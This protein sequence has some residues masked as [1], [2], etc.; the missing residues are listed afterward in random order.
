MTLGEL[1]DMLGVYVKNHR[2]DTVVVETAHSGIPTR[3]MVKLTNPSPG[4]DWTKGRFVFHTEDPIVPCKILDALPNELARATLAKLK[5]FHSRIHFQSLKK[6][7]YI[8]KSHDHSWLDG[9]LTGVRCHIT[10]VEL[11]EDGTRERVL[12]EITKER[13]T[14]PSDIEE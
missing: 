4:F 9:F 10:S 14:K 2:D 1:Y 12:D 7:S 8:P 3:V 11:G 13:N 6:S 5:A